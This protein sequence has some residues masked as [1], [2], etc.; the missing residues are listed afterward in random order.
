MVE[1]CADDGIL[2]GRSAERLQCSL[3]DL[4][5]LFERVGLVMK[6]EK[7]KAVTYIPGKNQ[8]RPLGGI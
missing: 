7:T 8:T 1:F 5:P 4:V 6:T 2:V 3:N